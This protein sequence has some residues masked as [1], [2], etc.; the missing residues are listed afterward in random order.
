MRTAVAELV[1]EKALQPRAFSVMPLVWTIGSI[2]GP[3]F[4]GALANPAK[5][6]PN[7]FGT[8]PFFQEF[9]FALP[10][11]VASAFFLV[12]LIIGVLFLEETLDTK[13]YQRDHGR[14]LGQLILGH[15][16]RKKMTKWADR[17]QQDPL[18]MH[19]R[20]SSAS[21]IGDDDESKERPKLMALGPPA[22]RE[23]FS[24]QSNMNLLAYSLLALHS[25]AFDQL[26][27]IF[28]HYPRQTDRT[29]NPDVR[30]PFKFTG[31]FGINSDRIGLLFMLYGI[32]GMVIQ[33]LIFPPLARRW[34][35]LTS[36][37]IVSFIF[38]IAYLIIPFTA[39]LPTPLTQQIGIFSIMLIKC[40][41][42]IFAFPCS[43]ILLTNSAKSLRILGT[44]N[45]V[46]VSISALGRAAGPAIGGS[47]FKLGVNIGYGILPWWTL[48]A[49]ALLAAIPVWWLVEMEG[50]GNTAADVDDENDDA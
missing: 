6:Y 29:A 35:V 43:T 47:T 42:V 2:F 3:A 14:A 45:G 22:Y 41:A 40:W 30:L 49:F 10:N 12:G 36:L 11:L 9:P 31:G 27:P 20:A 48:A 39:L 15:F 23:V 24:Y 13:R 50:F 26:L 1:P 28:M 33:F 16:R 17:E 25:V 32:V 8:S 46:A 7:I 38:P 4:G 18:L 44:L 34:G 37:K 19:S 21:T 5:K